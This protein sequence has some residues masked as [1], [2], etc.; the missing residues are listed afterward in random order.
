MQ[1]VGNRGM[2]A[3]HRNGVLQAKLEVGRQNARSE[4][5]AE[6]VARE[7]TE[8]SVARP[9]GSTS[10]RPGGLGQSLRIDASPRSGGT[11]GNQPV[12]ESIERGLDSPSGGRPLPPA[13]RSVFEPRLGRDFGDVRLHTGERATDLTRA[14]DAR[15]FAHGTDVYFGRG[16]YRPGTTDGR[17]LLAHELTHVVQQTGADRRRPD[18]STGPAV[19]QRTIGDGHDLQSNRFKGNVELEKVYDAEKTIDSGEAGIHVT[20][21]QQALVD[22]GFSLPRYGVDGDYGSETADAVEA[23]QKSVMK[24]SDAEADGRLDQET[25]EDL[26][27]HF[28][29]HGPERDV[30]TDPTR[31]LTEGTRTLS[32]KEKDALKKAI[33]TEQRTSSGALPTFNRN[34]SSASKPYEE[35]IKERVNDVVDAQYAALVSSRPARNPSNLYSASTMDN[36]AQKAKEATDDVF[37]RYLPSFAPGSLSWGVNV[38]DAYDFRD[39][40]I[41]TISGRGDWAA[42]WRVQKI[43]DVDRGIKQIDEEHGA[44][45]SRSTEQSLIAP[46][47]NQIVTN[48]RSE[49]LEIHKNWGGLRSGD[50]IYVQRYKASTD[51]ENRKKMWDLFGT[52]IHEYIHL[53]EH[54]NYETYRESLDAKKGGVVLREGMADYLARMVWENITF[55]DSLRAAVEGSFHDSA[56]PKA[57][58]IS[59]PGRYPQWTNAAKAVGIIGIRNALAAFFLGK[60]KFI[61]GP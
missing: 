56:N 59:P 20:I 2:Q 38:K 6:R 11:G 10:R 47:K 37:G 19:I 55:D 4:R 61:G 13:E 41:S 26:D 39:T 9:G 22:A 27:K 1:A 52:L 21:L 29:G 51:A 12:G 42:Q 28:L 3:L 31:S 50:K 7:V 36:V 60:T 5:E 25:M 34:I 43:L 30:A 58:S 57:H 40:N 8:A 14:L 23:F 46:V 54:P 15:A 45:Q 24:R 48:R 18:G 35:R 33:T 53:L 44:V 32:A 17:R 49:L 16:Q